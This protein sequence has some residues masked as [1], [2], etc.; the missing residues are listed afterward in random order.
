VETNNESNDQSDDQSDDQSNDP[1]NDLTGAG[2]GRPRIV[3]T[4]LALLER[5]SGATVQVRVGDAAV[6]AQRAGDELRVG[7]QVSVR[8]H[9]S[10]IH[11]IDADT[12]HV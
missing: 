10:R 6:L 7:D 4:V 12:V 3:G 9:R 5:M 11:V 1:A 8:L 2:G